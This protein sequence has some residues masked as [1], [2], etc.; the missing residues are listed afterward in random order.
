MVGNFGLLSVVY[1]ASRLRHA[2]LT[3]QLKARPGNEGKQS[4]DSRSGCPLMIAVCNIDPASALIQWL[5]LGGPMHGHAASCCVQSD[6][7]MCMNPAAMFDAALGLAPE[8]EKPAF[9]YAVYLDQLMVDAQRRQLKLQE[10]QQQ[11][12]QKVRHSP[13]SHHAAGSAVFLQLCTMDA[14]CL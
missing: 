11:L 2:P 14:S 4:L 5:A 6:G 3:W 8:W 13:C 9:C 1:S 12:L 10:A 7:A